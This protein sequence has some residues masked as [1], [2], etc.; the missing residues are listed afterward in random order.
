MGDAS[1]SS[2][3]SAGNLS[4]MSTTLIPDVNSTQSQENVTVCS[5]EYCDSDVEYVDQIL[6]YVFPN[7]FEWCLMVAYLVVFVVGMVG[8]FLVCWAVWRNQ[9]MRTVTNYF[10]VNLA[11][12]D[13]LVILL[14]LPPSMLED[15]TETWYMGSVMCKIVKYIQVSMQT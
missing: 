6:D 1:L 2:G 4:V 15:V 7:L 3:S 10:V 8:N 11:L 9:H 14:C 13:L 12:A 5:N